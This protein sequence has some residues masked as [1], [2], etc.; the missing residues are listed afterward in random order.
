M[1]LL[2][3]R[4]MMSVKELDTPTGGNDFG[5]EF[6]LYLE[7][8]YCDVSPLYTYCERAADELGVKVYNCVKSIID[9]YGESDSVGNVLVGEQVLDML[10]IEIYVENSKVI[11]LHKE[12]STYCL[13]TNDEYTYVTVRDNGLVF[14]EL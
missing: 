3:R 14:Y 11:A 4:M 10:G 8:D 2:R 7:F 13:I 1:S 6:P 12:Y 5:I 9:E